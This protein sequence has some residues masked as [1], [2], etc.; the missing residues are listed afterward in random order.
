MI[1]VRSTV[2]FNGAL[3]VL[4]ERLVHVV[5][6][7]SA[8]RAEIARV[9]YTLG[10]HAEIY[11]SYQELIDRRPD[12]GFVLAEDVE[13]FGGI[14]ELLAAMTAEMFWLPVVA[15][16]HGPQPSRVVMAIKAGALDYL[17]LPCDP[18]CLREALTGAGQEAEVRIKV[19]REAEKARAL[20]A[21]LTNREREVLSLLVAGSSNKTIARDLEI[22][23]RTV[24]IHRAH[25]MTKLGASHSADAVRI[26]LQ[27]SMGPGAVLAEPPLAA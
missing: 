16:A 8:D 2:L 14:R 1:T 21:R 24:E 26:W 4:S 15:L 19:Q 5:A 20:I 12:R 6:A 3:P 25:M 22:S 17:S 10:H 7:S 13:A 27:A 18:S 23:P 11:A 9:C